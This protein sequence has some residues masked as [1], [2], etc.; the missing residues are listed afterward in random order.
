MSEQVEATVAKA[1]SATN[2]GQALA[3]GV[4]EQVMDHNDSRA[5]FLLTNDGANDAWVAYGEAAV[6][7]SGHFLKAGGGV[8]G[9][10]DWPGE[11]H[12]FSTAATNVCFIEKS[13]ATGDDEGERPTGADAF[14]PTGPPGETTPTASLPVTGE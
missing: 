1:L 8:L 13:Y 7:H 5:S 9:D 11:V 12:V 4:D 14:V 6:A 10:D 3:G 2:G